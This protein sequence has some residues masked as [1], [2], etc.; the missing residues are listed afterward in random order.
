[1][2]LASSFIMMNVTLFPIV[3]ICKLLENKVL[4]IQFRVSGVSKQNNLTCYVKLSFLCR[5]K[6]LK[7]SRKMTPIPKKQH[8]ELKLGHSW[9]WAYLDKSINWYSHV[10]WTLVDSSRNNQTVSK[11]IFQPL[12]LVVVKELKTIT[13]GKCHFSPQFAVN[14]WNY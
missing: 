13:I 1:M 4:W 9:P 8:L 5:I 6:S 3:P 2:S 14:I 12:L 7:N 11:M 10:F